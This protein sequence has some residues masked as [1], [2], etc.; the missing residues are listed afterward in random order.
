M[1]YVFEENKKMLAKIRRYS[2]MLGRII[3]KYSN[4]LC[5]ENALQDFRRLFATYLYHR[6]SV[7]YSGLMTIYELHHIAWSYIPL[8]QEIIKV[9]EC[10]RHIGLIPKVIPLKLF[11]DI[12]PNRA[13][14]ILARCV[15]VS[16][17]DLFV[18]R[19]FVVKA[20]EYLQNFGDAFF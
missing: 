13:C 1:N 19:V 15:D 18:C 11:L 3:L 9:R 12:V 2:A 8:N 6:I 4:K 5:L 14:M 7:M 16:V 20:K 10:I 17:E